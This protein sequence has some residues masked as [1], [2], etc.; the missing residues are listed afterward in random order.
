MQNCKVVVDD[1]SCENIISQTLVDRLKLKVYK[2][3]RRY[4]VKRLMTDNEVQVRHTCQVTFAIGEDY[5][6]TTW[7]DV[8]SM[9]SGDILLGRPW[10]Y[11]KSD[12]H[13]MRDNTFTFMHSEKQVTLH[14]KKLEPPKKGSRANA[15]K[16]VLHVHHVYRGKM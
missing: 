4:L 5:Q 1:G 8:L 6:D 13:G 14:P 2:H 3:N 7:C 10:M 11:D 12:T 9:D 15:T 16:E